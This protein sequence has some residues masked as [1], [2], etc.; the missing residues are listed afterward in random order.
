[1][2]QKYSWGTWFSRHVMVMTPHNIHFKYILKIISYT[3]IIIF[4]IV[5]QIFLTIIH[6]V[7]I[8]SHWKSCYIK[9][10]LFL[11]LHLMISWLEKYLFLP[12]RFCL[13]NSYCDEEIKL[14]VDI[15]LTP[16]FVW[17]FWRK[18]C[19]LVGCIYQHPSSPRHCF[20]I[21]LWS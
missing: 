5:F 7:Y 2:A 16:L 12:S 11:R 15:P 13:H 17:V 19:S 6:S 20:E 3:S 8:N 1:M 10:P 4:I 21:F 18:F 9:I 14:C